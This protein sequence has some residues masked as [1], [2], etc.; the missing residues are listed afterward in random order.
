VTAQFWSR[1]RIER[2]QP[3]DVRDLSSFLLD[4]VEGA[5]TGVFNV[6]A[7]PDV[8]TYSEMLQA[9][10]TT[11]DGAARQP[12][13]LVWVDENWLVEQGVAQWT[14]L[15]LWRNAMA[16]W[17][18]SAERAQAAGLRCR[19]LANTVADTWEWLCSGRRTV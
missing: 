11:V 2:I 12:A 6:A 1:P 15:P 14:A 3:V 10:V 13:E 5:H 8:A 19:P 17:A 9:C 4:Q 7:P 18:M 16:P